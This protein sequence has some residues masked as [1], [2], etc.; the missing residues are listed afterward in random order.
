[1]TNGEGPADSDALNMLQLRFWEKIA[2]AAP[3][4]HFVFGLA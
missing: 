4:F 2:Q 3:Q 1:M